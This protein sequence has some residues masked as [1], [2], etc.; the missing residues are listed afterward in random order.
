MD[1][2]FADTMRDASEANRDQLGDGILK[3][4]NRDLYPN[5]TQFNNALQKELSQRFTMT[6]IQEH[7][8]DAMN[9]PCGNFFRVRLQQLPEAILSDDELL[10]AIL[11]RS[12]FQAI[13]KPLVAEIENEFEE[14]PWRIEEV[15]NAY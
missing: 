2:H 15:L 5:K 11:M 7:I 8:V 6:Y 1:A 3:D 9:D 13:K 12:V 10:S 4:A 14:N